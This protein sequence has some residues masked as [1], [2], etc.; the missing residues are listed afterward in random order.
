MRVFNA[1]FLWVAGGGV[2]IDF[3]GT[4]NHV[5][6]MGSRE[7]LRPV[8]RIKARRVAVDA[9]QAAAR[10]RFYPVFI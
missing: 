9:G 5:S 3:A 1:E 4:Y 8:F 2:P 6:K 10:A 7:A